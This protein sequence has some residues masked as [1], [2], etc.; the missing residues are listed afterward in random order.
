MRATLLCSTTFLAVLSWC[1]YSPSPKPRMYRPANLD[2]NEQDQRATGHSPMDRRRR[3]RYVACI[4]FG[5]NKNY[6]SEIIP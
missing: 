4:C 5:E 3:Y 6:Q 1:S 2:I